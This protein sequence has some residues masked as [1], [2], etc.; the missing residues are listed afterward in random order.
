MNE[1]QA[2]MP[3][4]L[5][6]AGPDD[7]QFLADL[8]SGL[9]ATAGFYR[10]MAGVGSPRPALIRGLLRSEPDRGAVLALRRDPAGLRAVGHASWAVTPAGAVDVGVVVA[11]AEQ[12]RGVGT[13]LFAAAAE[14]AA[15]AGAT[16]LHLDVHPE[17]RRVVASLRRRLG[18]SAFS[19]EHGLLNVEA[20]LPDAVRAV[21]S[22]PVA[23]AA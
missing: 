19:W 10:F 18:P 11:D 6:P 12:G 17:N 20:P 22:D 4:V 8:I 2:S 5:R 1:T 9:S 3:V 23:V 16:S 14:R 15:R 21:T 7:E 13:A